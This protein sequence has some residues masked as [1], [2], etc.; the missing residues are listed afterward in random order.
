[1]KLFFE[2]A[3]LEQDKVWARTAL[4]CIDSTWFIYDTRSYVDM[5]ILQSGRMC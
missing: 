1:M 2:V 5:Q 4:Y 3:W